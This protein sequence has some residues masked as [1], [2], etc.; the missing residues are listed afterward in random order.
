MII[1]S[2]QSRTLSI[3]SNMNEAF[4]FIQDLVCINH[5]NS[6][7]IVNPYAGL[8]VILCCKNTHLEGYYTSVD[9]LVK[10]MIRK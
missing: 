10:V 2:F 8:I 1:S 9:H 4:Y 6:Q 3:T 7:D 5:I